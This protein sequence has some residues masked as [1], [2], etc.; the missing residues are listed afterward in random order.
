MTR[1][2]TAMP[3]ILA[4]ADAAMRRRRIMRADWLADQLA[5]LPDH[6]APDGAG[7]EDRL[8]VSRRYRNALDV[9]AARIEDFAVAPG[10]VQM[11]AFGARLAML[12]VRAQS[13][14][15][16]AEACRLWIAKVRETAAACGD[17]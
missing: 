2:D 17:Q 3:D 12:G 5:A 10:R 13:T 14:G 15:G 4:A 6:R 16:V 8:A 7:L 9:L 11:G 1:I